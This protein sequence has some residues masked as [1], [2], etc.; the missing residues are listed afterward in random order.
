LTLNVTYCIVLLRYNI[1]IKTKEL[2]NMENIQVGTI[3]KTKRGSK[4]RI[5][6]IEKVEYIN[7]NFGFF[8]GT[9][10]N[11]DLSVYKRLRFQESFSISNNDFQI[12]EGG[13]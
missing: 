12:I 9:R 8:T 13:N 3:L 1:L 4:E 7:G 6:K 5:Y 10:L 2:E 11:K